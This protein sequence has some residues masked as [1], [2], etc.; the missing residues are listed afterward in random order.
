MQAPQKR[1]R[2]DACIVVY[3]AHSPAL[4]S[5]RMLDNTGICS[6]Y[7]RTIGSMT[8]ADLFEEYDTKGNKPVYTIRS[9]SQS[10]G[11]IS[12]PA[13][14]ARARLYC[15]SCGR[16]HHLAWGEMQNAIIQHGATTLSG[17]VDAYSWKYCQIDRTVPFR[18]NS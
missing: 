10:L 11:T 3:F 7:C 18:R 14:R 9:F 1:L 16:H 15:A 13:K 17:I 8:S 6:L 12:K 4:R 2:T 5:G